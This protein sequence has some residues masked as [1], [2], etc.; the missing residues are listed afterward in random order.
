VKL[1]PSKTNLRILFR[2]PDL[3]AQRYRWPLTGLTVGAVADLVT[4]LE[5]VR[6]YGPGV[7]LHFVQQLVFYVFGAAFGVPIA[8]AIQ[9]ACVVLVACWWRPWCT[10]ILTLCGMLYALAAVSNHFGLL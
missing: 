7:E 3:L 8:K 1:F 5:Q 6:R 4:T 10:W 2:R 9:V